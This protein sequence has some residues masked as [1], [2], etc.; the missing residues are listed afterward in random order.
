VFV[1]LCVVVQ[2]RS[3]KAAQELANVIEMRVQGH[4]PISLVGYGMVNTQRDTS[5]HN[6]TQHNAVPAL[7]V[8]YSSA[9]LRLVPFSPHS[10]IGGG[11]VTTIGERVCFDMAGSKVRDGGERYNREESTTTGYRL[12]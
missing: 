9:A 2:D 6:T 5:H 7:C 4:R 1:L 11:V 10:M 8:L 12:N 3:E